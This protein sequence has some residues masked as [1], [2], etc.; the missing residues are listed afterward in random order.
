MYVFAIYTPVTV[1]RKTYTR[2]IEC[3][4]YS[5]SVSKGIDCKFVIILN[6][7]KLSVDSIE[8]RNLYPLDV[9]FTKTHSL[10]SISHG[11]YF[12]QAERKYSVSISGG[13]YAVAFGIS[14]FLDNSGRGWLPALRQ[15]TSLFGRIFFTIEN[16]F[17]SL[18]SCFCCRLMHVNITNRIDVRVRACVRRKSGRFTIDLHSC[19]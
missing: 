18:C 9:D 8:L 5:T 11:L 17:L 19:S 16:F 4:L 10:S 14:G 2:K 12:C 3:L 13:H 1:A 7:L 15:T 6:V